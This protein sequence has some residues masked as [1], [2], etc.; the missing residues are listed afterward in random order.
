MDG[1]STT[2]SNKADTSTLNS[3]VSALNTSISS[4]KKS[5]IDTV[6]ARIDGGVAEFYQ[7]ASPPSFT[8]LGWT[9]AECQRHAG[10]LW[11]VVEP[12]TKG[13]VTGHLYRFVVMRG[14]GGAWEDVDDSIDSAT[15]VRQNASGWNVASG[16]FDKNGNLTDL[17]IASITP[18]VT[19]LSN[20]RFDEK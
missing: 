20:T 6:N 17:G 12:G 16:M 19:T 11:Y 7:Q 9:K 2:V 13:Y 15:T 14:T 8:N 18:T 1:I 10:A 5:A 4:A 3:K